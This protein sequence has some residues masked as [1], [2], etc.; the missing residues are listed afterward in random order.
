MKTASAPSQLPF[1][2][3]PFINELFSSW[4]LRIA[5]A[6]CVSLQE[7][8][9]GFQYLH[10]DVPCPNSLDWGFSPAFLKVMP[11]FCRTPISTLHSLDLR[12]RLPQAENVLSSA[13]QSSLRS[14]PAP[15]QTAGRLCLLSNLHC[16]TTL[17]ARSLGLGLPCPA[18]LSCS[19]A[20]AQTR[21]SNVWRRR[22]TSLRRF[23]CCVDPLLELRSTLDRRQ[24]WF[25]CRAR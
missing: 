3:R 2:P 9:L 22:P 7:L 13:L 5:D 8:M 16:S 21:M 1:A 19:Q 4:M 20:S 15:S 23:G 12:T 24:S 11:R 18:P 10:P 6:N 17:C 25:A 14:M